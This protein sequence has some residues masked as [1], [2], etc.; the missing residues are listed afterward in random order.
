MEVRTLL[1]P[2]WTPL[3][4]LVEKSHAEG[5]RF[6]IRFEQEYLSGQV[7]FDCPGETLLGAFEDSALVGM[8][9]LTRDPY[10]GDPRTGRVR[11]LYVLPDYRGR[12]IGRA[13]ITQ[14]ER[15]A[16]THFHSLVLRTDTPAGASFYHALGYEQLVAK[17]TATH[18]R[19]LLFD[20]LE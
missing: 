19:I 1:P 15:H 12:G 2:P 5:F 10:T 4:A 18:R 3:A 16:R 8:G 14:I 7:R 17:G 6:L 13:L 20:R 11:H 9:G